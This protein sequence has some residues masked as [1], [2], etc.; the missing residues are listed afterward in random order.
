MIVD[1]IESSVEQASSF[2]SHGTD[3]LRQASHYQ[4]KLRKKKLII[5]LI[6]AAIL[7]VIITIIVWQTN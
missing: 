2:V 6:L 3:Q 4:N 1:S 5:A 7:A